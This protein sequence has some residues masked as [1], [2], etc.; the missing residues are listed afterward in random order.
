MGPDIAPIRIA[1]LK[2]GMRDLTIVAKIAQ[3]GE[4]QTVMT[5][6]GQARVAAAVLEDETGS[7]RLNL[8]RDQIDK[9]R[10]GDSVR[11]ENAFIRMFNNQ[12]ELNIGKDG[13]I[14][15]LGKY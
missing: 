15:V 2:Q 13:K 8:W 9:V 6:F 10:V 3:I 5:R 12:N 11:L 14:T 1:E 4:V 7:I